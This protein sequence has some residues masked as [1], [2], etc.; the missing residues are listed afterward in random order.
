MK[1]ASWNV[2]G[3]RA[4]TKNGFVSWFDQQD[5]DVIGLQEVRALP[6]QIPMEVQALKAHQFWFPAQKKGYSGVGLLARERPLKLTCGLG[7]EEFDC[8]GRVITGEWDKFFF[9]SIY[10]PNSQDGGARLKYKIAF[11]EALAGW[12]HKLQKTGKAV[13]VSG[14]YNIAHQEIDLARPDDNHE[15]A[16]FLPEERQWMGQFLNQGW[17]DSFRYLHPTARDMYTWWS[18]RMR[19]RERNVG[20]RID[21]LCVNQSHQELIEKAGMQMQV[22]GSDHCPAT[23]E[24]RL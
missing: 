10:F 7:L 5:F 12:V 17:V 6:D 20:W 2:N 19:A 4:C 22:L 18:A 9:L 8:E 3:I 23:I 24:L 1:F 11:C 13:V 16:G 21:Y 15:S 14:D